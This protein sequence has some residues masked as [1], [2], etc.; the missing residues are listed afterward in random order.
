MNVVYGGAESNVAAALA[1]W[2]VPSKLV[3][4][5]PF[6]PLGD[7]AEQHLKK[8]DIGA[9][10]VFRTGDRLG[11]YFVEEGSSV[12]STQVVYDRKDSS[13]AKATVGQFD[14]EFIFK[15]ASWFHTT[16]ITAGLSASLATETVNALRIAKEKGLITSFDLNYRAQLWGRGAAKLVLEKILPYVDIFV[17]LDTHLQ[18]LLGIS[19][20]GEAKDAPTFY[21]Q[22]IQQRYGCKLVATSL[23]ESLSPTTIRWKGIAYD[24]AT[25][26]TSAHY[27]LSVV[28]RIGTGDAFTAGLIYALMHNKNPQEVLE[29]AVAAGAWKHTVFGDHMIASLS[30]IES[31]V[32]GD[33]GGSI[34]R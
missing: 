19:F 10:H 18:D 28:D 3:T 1:A 27:D 25:H 29:F 20:S 23:R 22:A 2:R 11:I 8:L 5:L 31:L 14:W 6:N 26:F 17:G 7:A 34:R 13:F 16:G 15:D 33:R 4:G 21:L 9:E 24:G 32:Q 30:E 12:R